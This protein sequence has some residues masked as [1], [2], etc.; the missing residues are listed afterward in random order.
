VAVAVQ[1]W[2]PL[3]LQPGTMPLTGRPLLSTNPLRLIRPF[4]VAGEPAKV[5]VC[6][7]KSK[8]RRTCENARSPA[9]TGSWRCMPAENTNWAL[10]SLLRCPVITLAS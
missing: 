1:N 6:E 2:T 4:G 9:N 8:A 5:G 10:P 7:K 3:P